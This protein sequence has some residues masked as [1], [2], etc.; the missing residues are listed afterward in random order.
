V[1][2]DERQTLAFLGAV[3]CP[4]QVIAGWRGLSLDADRV[5]AR[6]AALR[7]RDPVR[8][9]G[10]HH[11]HLDSPREVALAVTSFISAWL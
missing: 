9:E 10:G 3:E 11:V 6:L 8:I 4:T 5:R 7:V 2:L 1:A